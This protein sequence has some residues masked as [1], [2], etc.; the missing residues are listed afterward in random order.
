MSL[1]DVR[2]QLG[3]FSMALAAVLCAVIGSAALERTRSRAVR[4]VEVTG[5]AKKRI[6]SDLIEWHARVELNAAERTKAYRELTGHAQAVMAYL[7]AQGVKAARAV[8][9][10]SRSPHLVPASTTSANAAKPSMFS[11]G[12]ASS[13]RC[14]AAA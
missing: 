1:S 10:V 12:R 4:K 7:G 3:W 2:S 14:S 13:V 8:A 9:A 5:S 11:R 6:V